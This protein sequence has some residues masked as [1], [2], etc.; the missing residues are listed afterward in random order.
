MEKPPLFSNSEI[1]NYEISLSDWIS[2]LPERLHAAPLSWLT[3]P[4]SHDSGSYGLKTKHGI[5]PDKPGLQKS[6][7][8]KIFS[9]IVLP[10]IK[11]WTKTQNL[12]ITDQLLNGIRYF[13]FRVASMKNE[14]DLY[15]VHGLYGDKILDLCKEI[16]N[17]LTTYSKEIV[18]LDFQHF[19]SVS[20]EQHKRLIGKIT[21]I[22][23]SKVCPFMEFKSP[24]RTSLKNLW[25][26]KYQVLVYYRNEEMCKY[27]PKLWPS[28]LLPNPWANTMDVNYLVKFLT[29][30]VE[31]RDEHAFYVTQGVLTPDNKCVVLNWT[32]TLY[33]KLAKKCN[34]NLVLW[35]KDKTTGPRGPNIAMIDFIEWKDA[36]IPKIVVK[37]NYR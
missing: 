17:F 27:N 4:G 6:L 18:I 36:H 8:V 37:M 5:A 31:S 24:D 30:N 29:K 23:G 35:L 34:E 28:L 7:L 21:E 10:I 32:T 13:D 20:D 33:H 2:N 19:Y 1:F 15:F 11:R 9:F 3:I 14:D 25:S 12:T 22:F 26:N 16:D